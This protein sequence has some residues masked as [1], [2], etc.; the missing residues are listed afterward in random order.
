MCVE[1]GIVV[2]ITLVQMYK[3][4]GMLQTSML[5]IFFIILTVQSLFIIHLHTNKIAL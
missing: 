1:E 5:C 2:V 4:L 3:C